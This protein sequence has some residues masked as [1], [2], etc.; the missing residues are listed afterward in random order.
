MKKIMSNEKYYQKNIP[1]EKRFQSNVEVDNYDNREYAYDSYSTS[2][3]ALQKPILRNILIS[4]K[5]KKNGELQI[6]DFA[7]GTGRIAQLLEE[8]SDNIDGIDTSEQMIALARQR[9]KKVHFKVGN[10]LADHTILKPSYDIITIFRFLLNV[11]PNVRRLILKKLREV[12]SV[13]DGILVVNVHGNSRS[14]RHPVILY[15]K[16]QQK[17]KSRF[18]SYGVK[19][20]QMLNEM[21]DKEAIILLQES[22]F[23]IIDKYGF[24]FLPGFLYRTCLRKH[25]MALDAYFVKK[26]WLKNLSIDILYICRPILSTHNNDSVINF[27]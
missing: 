26:R 4:C 25:V 8:S 7:C 5:S 12:I 17:V 6:L 18:A 10:I 14:A 27:C 13:P 9:T 2:I 22:G 19:K 16:W 21:S 24:G 15:R 1:Y 23:E 20:N 11:E 3:W